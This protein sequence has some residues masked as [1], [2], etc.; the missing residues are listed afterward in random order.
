MNLENKIPQLLMSLLFVCSLVYYQ[1]AS[2]QAILHQSYSNPSN[3]TTII[4]YDLFES[5]HVSLKVYDVLGRVVTTLVD[6]YET[7]GSHRA[8]FS[9]TNL[10]SGVYFYNLR[11]GSFNGT[12]KLMFIK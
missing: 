11:V 8:T 3:P 9:A 7:A 6:E 5:S 1:E 10:S 2:A 12:G 4:K